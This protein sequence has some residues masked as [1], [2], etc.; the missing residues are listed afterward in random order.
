MGETP[1]RSPNEENSELSLSSRG[2]LNNEPVLKLIS[3]AC[4]KVRIQNINAKI[5]TRLGSAV[6]SYE[7]ISL[8]WI[9]CFV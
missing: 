5:M 8:S 9:E 3:S 6:M 7:S 2:R 4:T 1:F